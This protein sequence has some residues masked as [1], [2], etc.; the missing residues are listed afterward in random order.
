MVGYWSC[1]RYSTNLKIKIAKNTD[2]FAQG[3]ASEVRT[4]AAQAQYVTV[5]IMQQRFIDF[6]KENDNQQHSKNLKGTKPSKMD[7][8]CNQIA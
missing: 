5:D 4:Q 3:N 8:I 6:V 2:I 1:P 7:G